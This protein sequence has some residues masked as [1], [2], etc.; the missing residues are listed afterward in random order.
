MNSIPYEISRK[1]NLEKVSF[2]QEHLPFNIKK[3][4][5][6]SERSYEQLSIL[7]IHPIPT[8]VVDRHRRVLLWN[9]ALEN[10]LNISA[11]DVIGTDHYWILFFDSKLPQMVDM[12][13]GGPSDDSDVTNAQRMSFTHSN[14]IEGAY[15]IIE[16][17]QSLGTSGKWLRLTF[18]PLADG[19]GGE[20]FGAAVTFEDITCFKEYEQALL[21]REKRHIELS[22]TDDLTKLH[23]SRQFFHQLKNEFDRS[24]RYGHPL[25]LLMMDV[26][27]FKKLN[28]TYG[29]LEGDRV[30][31]RIGEIIRDCIRK[32]DSAY[33]YGGEE[34]TVILPETT[35][36]DAVVV[37]ERI[38]KAISD[39]L[40][41]CDGDHFTVTASI[42]IALYHHNETFETLLKNADKSMYAAKR[43]SK[44]CVCLENSLMA[45]K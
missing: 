21:E 14:R 26:D 41:S 42:G 12:L 8:L 13:I 17:F 44:N 22:I 15:E 45:Q 3:T 40:F 25:A 5:T 27:N 35:G 31:R 43:H 37:A 7:Q 10:L 11:E 18:A 16:H 32:T 23:N 24:Q 2:H 6:A 30:L 28:D 20:D 38:R 1:A 9:K 33:R 19:D 36:E 34:F 29:H 39:D 4:D